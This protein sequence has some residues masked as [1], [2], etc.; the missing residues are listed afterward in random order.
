[1]LV[2]VIVGS[3]GNPGG[4]CELCCRSLSGARPGLL[5]GRAGFVSGSHGSSGPGFLLLG[6]VVVLGL[7]W[8]A[9]LAMLVAVLFFS[10]TP[11]LV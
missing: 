5:E 1:M 10:P 2:F 3:L 6:C 4:Y 8:W 7:L 11:R 9:Y